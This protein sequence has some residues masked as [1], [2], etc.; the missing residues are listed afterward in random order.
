M[1]GEPD[2]IRISPDP[3]LLGKIDQAAELM[4]LSRSEFVLHVL[5][6]WEKTQNM[7]L[8]GHNRL[9]A[10][11]PDR[12]GERDSAIPFSVGVKCLEG[13]N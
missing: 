8:N 5:R 9:C 6:F 10:L 11:E 12:T 4:G 2:E 1:P 7:P 3:V 13:K